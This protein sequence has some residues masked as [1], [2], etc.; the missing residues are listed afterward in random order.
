MMNY[1]K[2]TNYKEVFMS[3]KVYD[4]LKTIALVA[5]PVLAFVAAVVSIWNVPYG[6]ELTATLTAID[7]LLGAIVVALKINHDKKVEA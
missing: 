3:N 1:W 4:T 2:N 7:T 6:A 5:T